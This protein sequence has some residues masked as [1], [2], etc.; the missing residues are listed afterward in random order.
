MPAVPVLFDTDI[1]GDV[2]DAL[3]LATLLSAPERL[4]LV[5]VT[6]VSGD[7]RGLLELMPVPQLTPQQKD[8]LGQIMAQWA[9]NFPLGTFQE[10]RASHPQHFVR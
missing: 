6:T 3:A 7:T 1:S 5:A 4:R 8:A 2:D 9:R 10:Y